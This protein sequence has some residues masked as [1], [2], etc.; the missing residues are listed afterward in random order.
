M[1]IIRAPPRDDASLDG[2]LGDEVDQ[3]FVDF[4]Y[5]NSAYR[6]TMSNLLPYFDKKGY[7]D[8]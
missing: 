3:G 7:L 4:M 6:A 1:P 5:N 2:I 8:I